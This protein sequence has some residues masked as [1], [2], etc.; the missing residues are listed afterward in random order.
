[1][2]EDFRLLLMTMDEGP[3]CL[4][5]EG[6]SMNKESDALMAVSVAQAAIVGF[7]GAI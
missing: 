4:T 2:Y 3:S 7:P 5:G 6:L 1:M